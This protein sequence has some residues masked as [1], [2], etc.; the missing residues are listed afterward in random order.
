LLLKK[1]LTGLALEIGNVG[2]SERNLRANTLFASPT[3]RKRLGIPPDWD[4][5]DPN[6]CSRRL[7]PKDKSEVLAR[8]EACING[9]GDQ[10]E[11]TSR[12][13]HNEGICR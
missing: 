12:W 13:K 7:N 10:F 2:L 11:M 4:M 8:R 6:Q 5:D 1:T 9:E 3:Y